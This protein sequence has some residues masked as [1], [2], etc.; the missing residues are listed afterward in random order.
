MVA[1]SRFKELGE[2]AE[3]KNIAFNLGSSSDD[4]VD[5]G[6]VLTCTSHQCPAEQ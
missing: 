6:L 4:D 5:F 3:A 2:V 1:M